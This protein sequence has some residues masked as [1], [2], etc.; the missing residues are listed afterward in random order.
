MKAPL[1]VL[2][3]GAKSSLCVWLWGLRLLRGTPHLWQ[4][5]V[6]EEVQNP[7][8][9]NPKKPG[10]PKTLH[11]TQA[12]NPTTRNP[13]KAL[14]GPCFPPRINQFLSFGGQCSHGPS[15]PAPM[16]H[17]W[18]TS[19]EELAAVS[20]ARPVLEITGSSS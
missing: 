10:S 4:F 16:L 3:W 11:P 9:L 13:L 20:V 2:V 6:A 7:K 8:S 15:L 14:A 12:L 18:L 5:H 19:G 1:L 17:V